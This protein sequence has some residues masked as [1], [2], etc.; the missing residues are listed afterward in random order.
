MR[1]WSV[2]RHVSIRWRLVFGQNYLTT[3]SISR[4]FCGFCAMSAFVTPF[5]VFRSFL[6]IASAI[7]GKKTI[8]HCTSVPKPAEEA[9]QQ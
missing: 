4:A 9:M 8:K 2:A 1:C 5:N 3:G 7:T 6:P